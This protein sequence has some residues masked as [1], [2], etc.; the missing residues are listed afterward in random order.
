MSAMV[1]LAAGFVSEGIA[2]I[3]HLTGDLNMLS[4]TLIYNGVSAKS[5]VKVIESR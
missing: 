1:D 3:V 5:N 4:D 2:T